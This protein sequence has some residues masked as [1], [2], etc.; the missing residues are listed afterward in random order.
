MMLEIAKYFM[1]SR[2]LAVLAAALAC[3]QRAPADDAVAYTNSFDAKPG[4]SFPE[5]SSSLIAY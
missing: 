2:S 1:H 5:W 4:A 3:Y